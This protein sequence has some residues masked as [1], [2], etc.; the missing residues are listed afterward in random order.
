MDEFKKWASLIKRQPGDPT[1]R[2]ARVALLEKAIKLLDAGENDDGVAAELMMWAA[3]QEQ[4]SGTP[5]PSMVSA[6]RAA[7]EA[8]RTPT[9]SAS[10]SPEA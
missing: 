8:L 2:F 9:P 4:T 7:G 5:Y 1:E 6:F 3:V 10:T